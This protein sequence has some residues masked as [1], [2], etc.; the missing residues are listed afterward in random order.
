MK[1]CVTLK[2]NILFLILQ[3]SDILLTFKST[4]NLEGYLLD[5]PVIILCEDEELLS[6]LPTAQNGF[7]CEDS[8]KNQYIKEH[9]QPEKLR[10]MMKKCL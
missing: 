5:K 8:K 2:M 7:L 6:D 1:M 3:H 9:F 10:T 4:T